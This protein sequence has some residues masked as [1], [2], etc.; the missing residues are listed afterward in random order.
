M[1]A[2]GRQD[3]Q[4]Q[5]ADS[6]YR[7]V[8][9]LGRGSAA[10]VLLVEHKLIGKEFALKIIHR[11]L[12]D[13]KGYVER[14][15]REARAIAKAESDHIVRV[16]DLSTTR[17]GRP[18][19]VLERLLGNNLAEELLRRRSVSLEEWRK[20]TTE[21]LIGLDAAH[22]Q[23]IVHRDL[24]PSNIFLQLRPDTPRQGAMGRRTVKIMD[25]GLAGLSPGVSAS[26]PL[27]AGVATSTGALLG[28]PAYAS[29]EALRGEPLDARADLYAVGLIGFEMLTGRSPM[30]FTGESFSEG[31]L[32]EAIA[33]V[34]SRAAHRDR[35]RRFQSTAE[36]VEALLHEIPKDVP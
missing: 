27:I 24:S 31:A 22:Q 8:G 25:F 29:P 17:D 36:F 11:H 1:D 33:A 30:E 13:Q 15:A 18:F 14:L 20:W 6:P 21:L 7:V 9:H 32:P 28:T 16:I 34:L 23:G 3:L 19:I 12:C 10:E 2:E 26:V 35:E 5:L 4:R